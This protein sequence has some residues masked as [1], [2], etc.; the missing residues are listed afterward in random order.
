MRKWK[1]LD[2]G[3]LSECLC[4]KVVLEAE[5]SLA[6]KCSPKGCEMIWVSP[7]LIQVNLIL[8]LFTVPSGM[9][10]G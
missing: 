10:G 3:P 7:A 1:A 6:A 8:T 2:I 4:G 5:H 9:L